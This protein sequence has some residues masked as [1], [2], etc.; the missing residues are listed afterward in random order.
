[1]FYFSHL[2]IIFYCHITILDFFFFFFGNYIV[3]NGYD[4]IN[5]EADVNDY[6]I[7]EDINNGGKQD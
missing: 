2:L 3:D 5:L 6:P 4:D 1:M 7:S